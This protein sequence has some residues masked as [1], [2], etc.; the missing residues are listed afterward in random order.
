MRDLEPCRPQAL[1]RRH[2]VGRED[3]RAAAAER[4]RHRR[5][6]AEH[7]DPAGFEG[8]HAVVAGEDEAGR[9]GRA[10]LGGDPL[11]A[12]RRGRPGIEAV[13]RA[14]P[15]GKPQQAQDLR[16]DRRLGDAPVAHGIDE[17]VAPRAV[18]SGHGEVERRVAG[19]LGAARRRPVRHHEPV[20]LPLVVQDLLEHRR[21]GHRR[22][23]DGVVGGHDGP[24]AG[25]AHDRLERRQVQLPQRPLVDP[26]LEREA[27]GLGVVGHEVLD[28]G[29]DA[30]GL[31]A[32][33][34]GRPDPAGQQRV[35]AEG[36]EVAAA[37]RRAVEVDHRREHD[38]DALAARLG[39]QQAAEPLDPRLVPGGRQQ[40]RRRHVGRRLALVPALATH[41]GRAVGRHQPPQPDRRLVVQRPEV[42]A[43]EQPHL[44]LQAEPPQPLLEN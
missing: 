8:E 24:G 30:L 1:E 32:A 6:R 12:P 11:V 23:V 3:R 16:V 36:L 31:Q 38:V 21:L 40:R 9:G 22:A 17:G 39:G 41:A 44:L 27:L 13:E 33:H 7:G 25:V 29:G 2:G 37:V 19:G 5:A 28:R 18:R 10:Q 42:G 35:L 34:V 15:R 20:P 4:A 26:R 14:D 43:G